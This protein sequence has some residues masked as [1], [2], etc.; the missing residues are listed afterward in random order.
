MVGVEEGTGDE[1]RALESR[2][3]VIVSA[4]FDLN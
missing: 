3:K 1:T 2:F 4:L